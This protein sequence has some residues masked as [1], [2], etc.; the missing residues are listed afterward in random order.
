MPESSLPRSMPKDAFLGFMEAALLRSNFPCDPLFRDFHGRFYDMVYK[1]LPKVREKASEIQVDLYD[2]GRPRFH[3]TERTPFASLTVSVTIVFSLH[4]HPQ[5]GKMIPV[6]FDTTGFNLFIS[7]NERDGEKRVYHEIN[8]GSVGIHASRLTMP[9][10]IP[11]V[12]PD[13]MIELLVD[14]I[15][16]SKE[17]HW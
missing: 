3:I 15:R 10:A 8:L 11:D 17:D 4:I 9:N 2:V 14:E 5:G 16:Y 13:E 1:T 7:V 12:L 6:P